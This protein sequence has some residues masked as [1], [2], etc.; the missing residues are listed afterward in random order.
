MVETKFL[1]LSL[2]AVKT[3]CLNEALARL[4]WI[5]SD[6]APGCRLYFVKACLLAFS[7]FE[8]ADVHQQHLFLCEE[9]PEVS[10]IL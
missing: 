1:Q 9:I 2:R 7:A 3:V 4:Y 8:Q 10:G 5:H 6:I